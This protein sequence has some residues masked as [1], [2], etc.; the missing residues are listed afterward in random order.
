MR[1]IAAWLVVYHHYMQGFH[2][3]NSTSFVGQFFTQV[4]PFGVDVFFVVSGF[5]MVYTLRL[6]QYT[7][8]EFLLRRVIRI[9]PA[10]WFMTLAFM[11]V[12]HEF[13][14]TF[15]SRF[16]WDLSSLALSL[17]FIP[18]Q[19]PSGM[20]GFPLLTVGWTLN[21]EMFFYAWLSVMLCVF[22]RAWF[23]ACVASL[24][25]VPVLWNKSWPYGSIVGGN[26]L[27]EF[28][29]GMVLAQMYLKGRFTSRYVGASLLVLGILLCWTDFTHRPALNL[30]RIP[31]LWRLGLGNLTLH[32]S[33]AML[34][35]AALCFE[36]VFRHRA[37]RAMR[38]LGD[39]SY[40][41]YLVH[42]LALCVAVYL[43]GAPPQSRPGEYVALL[44]YTALT[45]GLSLLSYR[46][47]EMG[48]ATGLL[49]RTFLGVRQDAGAAT[50]GTP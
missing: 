50:A 27:Y 35:G 5:I 21:Y 4:G 36:Q 23:G 49:K 44:L 3:F 18:H 10:Y 43:L 46:W 42:P 16:Q 45:L 40:S 12:L 33:A 37:F 14:S 34:V 7:A 32:A 22:P 38:A 47:I 2:G 13:P 31:L 25:A 29:L 28:A 8:A 1:A 19:H 20:G 30:D 48:P 15:A 24:L 9:V 11:V 26:L 6:G 39:I 17:L 41:T